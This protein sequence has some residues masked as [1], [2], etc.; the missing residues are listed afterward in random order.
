MLNQFR[1][2]WND[3]REFWSR[4]YKTIIDKDEI[5]KNLYKFKFMI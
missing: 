3:F 4:F 5:I 2:K 1:F